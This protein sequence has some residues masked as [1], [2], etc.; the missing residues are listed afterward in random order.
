[1]LFVLGIFA[2]ICLY[3]VKI[4]KK[5]FSDY[6]D[7]EQTTMIKGIFAFIIF[8]CHFNS[9]I[10]LDNNLLNKIFE[11]IIRYIGQLSV[12]MF[13]FYSGF[14]IYISATKKKGYFENFW[15]KRIIKTLIAFDLA[16]LLYLICDIIMSINYPIKD[17]LLSFVGWSSVGNSNWFVFVIIV[18]YIITN[19]IAKIFKNKLDKKSLITITVCSIILIIILKI[20]K[21]SWWYN[22]ILCYPLGLWYGFYK[23]KIDDLIKRKYLY[24]FFPLFAVFIALF[25][26]RNYSFIVYEI[27]SC[28]FCILVVCFTYKVKLANKILGFFGKYSFEIYILQRLPYIFILKY[29]SNY[30]LI[31]FIGFAST[32]VLSILFSKLT[33]F[34]NKLMK[35]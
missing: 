35:I 25:Y 14:G 16:V 30:Y 18:L 32:I 26:F 12:V 29:L 33:K 23:D 10:V 20:L 2:I 28:V 19:V 17:I 24:V 8:V 1:M 13:L 11:T 21:E 27:V 6:L 15:K 3:K 34:V 9:Y 31:F 7:I 5:G 22:T 4:D